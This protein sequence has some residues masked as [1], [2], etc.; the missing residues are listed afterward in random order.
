MRR[1]LV[2]VAG[3][4]APQPAVQP[5]ASLLRARSGARRTP[6]LTGGSLCLFVV[7]LSFGCEAGR[8]PDVVHWE[9]TRD[10]PALVAALRSDD[11]L[12]RVGAVMTLAKVGDERAILP[13]LQA[14]RLADTPM[15]VKMAYALGRIDPSWP[16]NEIVRR[17]IPT[18]L[19]DL[20]ADDSRKRALAVMVLGRM[21]D[22][23]LSERLMPS[24][25]DVSLSVR[26]A[27]IE[28][29][30]GYGAADFP[31]VAK[32]VADQPHGGAGTMLAA[33]VVA[34]DRSPV[35]TIVV[36]FA[37]AVRLAIPRLSW[38]SALAIALLGL[39]SILLMPSGREL[40]Y[41]QTMALGSLAVFSGP[42]A[43]AFYVVA[44]KAPFV[45]G[46]SGLG[47]MLAVCGIAL[48][49]G[50]ASCGLP[51]LLYKSSAAFFV[52]D[53]GAAIR[54]LH[55]LTLWFVRCA[56]VLSGVT[57]ICLLLYG[58]IVSRAAAVFVTVPDIA[59]LVLVAL[60]AALEWSQ[61]R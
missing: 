40:R 33:S 15:R 28:A 2:A 53:A 54:A 56:F 14:M 47:N 5:T 36:G 13:L 35:G 18:L 37:R 34:L 7:L 60:T 55:I 20:E 12:T 48:L 44:V 41:Q 25:G 30:P 17:H 61:V 42:I 57:L 21:R 11:E 6:Q 1:S 26:Q 24:L 59:A 27:A 52:D 49:W 38:G 45:L 8:D 58:A 19:A 4:A 10:V 16:R 29:L 39:L 22:P 3:L 51:L 31:R 32:F 23:K 9:R 43:M 50:L 46:V